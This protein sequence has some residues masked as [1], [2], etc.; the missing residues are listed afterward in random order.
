MRMPLSKTF[1]AKNMDFNEA[2]ICF[3]S[4]FLYPVL[5]NEEIQIIGGA[6][7]QQKVLAELFCRHKV[8]V[9]VVTMDFGQCEIGKIDDITIFR[10]YRSDAGLPFI[11]F[12]YP[13]FYKLWRALTRANASHYYQRGSGM[14]TGIVAFFCKVHHREFIFS[15]ASDADFCPTLPLLPAIKDKIMYQYGIANANSIVVQ[16]RHQ[17]EACAKL[18]GRRSEVIPSCLQSPS[19]ISPLKRKYV[20]WVANIK[21]IKQPLLV[22]ELAK[23][24]S[25]VLF[26]IV[27]APTDANLYEKL[28]RAAAGLDNVEILGFVPYTAIGPEFDCARLLINTSKFEGFPNTFLQAFSRGVPV[29]CFDNITP[30][31]QHITHPAANLRAMA[32]TINTLSLDDELWARES[33][34]SRKYFLENHSTDAIVEMY[35]EI[36][37]NRSRTRVR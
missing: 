15:S 25:R 36:F 10:T 9:S 24:C 4:P 1:R 32:Q 2:S 12:F 31:I 8:R 23:M 26:R 14:L 6:E 21:P 18:F 33:C 17:K 27:G 11:R 19:G 35:L 29:I 3:V 22:L 34:S 30:E 5:S 13:R 28:V 37:R 7:V 20:L 16:N